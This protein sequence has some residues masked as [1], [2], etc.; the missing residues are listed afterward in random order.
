MPLVLSGKTLGVETEIVSPRAGGKQFA[1]FQ[2]TTIHLLD[3]I[4]VHQVEVQQDFP[5]SDLPK[6]DEVVHLDC[7]VSAFATR[8]GAGYRLS[9]SGRAKVAAA[10]VPTPLRT[11][12]GS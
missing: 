2:R 3:G 5:T 12:S 9:T 10:P 4:R 7:T 1:A 6:A 11:A 8:T